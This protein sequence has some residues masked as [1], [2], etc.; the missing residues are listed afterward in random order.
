MKPLT[1]YQRVSQYL[2]KIFKL[3]NEEYF[4]SSLEIPTITIQSTV[5]LLYTSHISCFLCWIRWK[6]VKIN[7]MVENST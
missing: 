2:V 4:N 1:N 5:C 7:C 3:V 6:M